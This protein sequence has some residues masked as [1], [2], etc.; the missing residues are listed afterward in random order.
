MG[1]NNTKATKPHLEAQSGVSEKEEDMFV[2]LDPADILHDGKLV[3][4]YDNLPIEEGQ[5]AH[6]GNV[7]DFKDKTVEE[8]DGW[9]TAT[10]SGA[11]PY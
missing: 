9:E 4:S 6:E 10:V 8:I 3:S 5:T 11:K 7:E 1:G 2:L